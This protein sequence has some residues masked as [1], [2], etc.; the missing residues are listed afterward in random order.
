MLFCDVK[1]LVNV[2]S[3]VPHGKINLSY[4]C[5]KFGWETS[6]LQI[7]VLLRNLY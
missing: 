4:I 1:G 6:S 3:I 2:M 5:S 7:F